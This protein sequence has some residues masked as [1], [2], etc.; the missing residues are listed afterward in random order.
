MSTPASSPLG[1]EHHVNAAHI[2]QA[3][4]EHPPKPIKSVPNR[5]WMM[6][7]ADLEGPGAQ[8]RFASYSIGF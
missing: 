6:K 8:Y 1:S 5:I 7:A 4:E 3:M 2:R